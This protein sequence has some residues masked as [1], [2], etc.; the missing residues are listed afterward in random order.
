MSILDPAKLLVIL[1]IAAIVLGP[2]RLPQVARTLGGLWRTAG[3]YRERAEHELRDTL[4]T[5]QIPDV[6]AGKASRAVGDHLAHLAT[7]LPASS[8]VRA[9]LRDVKGAPRVDNL[10]ARSSRDQRGA[11]VP[12]QSVH[13]A[14]MN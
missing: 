7:P 14:E 11:E 4:T 1:T 10:G 5:L 13:G 3:Q 6:V 12:G 9:A 2:E 8:L